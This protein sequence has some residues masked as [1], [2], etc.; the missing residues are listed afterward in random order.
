MY[1][2]VKNDTQAGGECKIIWS[3]PR[4]KESSV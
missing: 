4:G 3:L 2:A 1:K